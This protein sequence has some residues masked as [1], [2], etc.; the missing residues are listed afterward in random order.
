[1][2]VIKMRN[3]TQKVL[4]LVM[5][6]T[7]MLSNYSE[8]KTVA[9]DN[10]SVSTTFVSRFPGKKPNDNE[11][12]T[13]EVEDDD[14]EDW[15]AH[16]DD[17]RHGLASGNGNT[18]SDSSSGGKGTATGPQSVKLCDGSWY[19]YH[20]SEQGCVYALNADGSLNLGTMRLSPRSDTL[21]DMGCGLWSTAMIVS[22]LHGRPICI[23]ELL[24]EMGA[25]INGNIIQVPDDAGYMVT[26][27]GRSDEFGA[28]VAKAW[29]LE[30]DAW[31][32]GRTKEECK[33]AVDACL[34]AGG[35]VR[36]RYGAPDSDVSS[37]AWPYFATDGHFIT[38]RNK[39]EDGKYLILD[40]CFSFCTDMEGSTK[41]A[42]TPIDWDTL[43][44]Y[45]PLNRSGSTIGFGFICF[46]PKGEK[47]SSTS[48]T[49][50]KPKSQKSTWNSD[51]TWYGPGTDIQNYTNKKDLGQ[52]F[53]L[54]DGL[55]WTADDKTYTVDTDTALNDWFVYMEK[56]SGDK[57]TY[58]DGSVATASDIIANSNRLKEVDG[59]TF[60]GSP[61]SWKTK[62][63]GSYA[64][65]DGLQAVPIC[66]PPMVVDTY[67]NSDFEK[68]DKLSKDNWTNSDT[69]N[70]SK[71]KFGESK[72]AVALYEKST[73]KIWFM[74]VVNCSELNNTYPGGIATTSFKVKSG[75]KVYENVNKAIFGKSTAD[76]VSTVAKFWDLPD[77]VKE[78]IG[79]KKDYAVCGYVVWE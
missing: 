42:N 39:T 73:K 14:D 30:C 18:G 55:P 67:F 9:V 16:K 68:S 65:I 49:G 32:D 20:Q 17:D 25:T 13:V 71:Y 10:S 74:P 34:D 76:Y 69:A 40:S 31:G 8:I 21:K 45:A 50:D 26:C 75:N 12:S 38:I 7:I 35:M 3:K 28:A 11:D 4:A 27:D 41:Q 24:T 78:V 6:F 19:W 2:W 72:M 54:Y 46:T 1:M 79:S 51:C 77:V 58:G 37:T 60:K 66:V 61:G 29:N 43:Y 56:K 63:G 33:A 59:G 44:K 57:L 70:E 22:N 47:S 62:N 48:A 53:Y 52:G 36:F 15:V 23:D 5:T 64:E